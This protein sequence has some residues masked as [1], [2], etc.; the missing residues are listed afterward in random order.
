[1]Q[2]NTEDFI[3]LFSR[4]IQDNQITLTDEHWWTRYVTEVPK[5]LNE[6]VMT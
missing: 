5:I 2:Y 1:M 6:T 3:K 4:N